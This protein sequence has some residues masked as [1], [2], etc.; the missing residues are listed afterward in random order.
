MLVNE[1][2]IDPA[3]LLAVLHYDGT[4]ITA[5]YITG[6]ITRQVHAYAVKPRKKAKVK[7]QVGV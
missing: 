5:R 7:A 6:A 1:L 4:P 2:G 3:R